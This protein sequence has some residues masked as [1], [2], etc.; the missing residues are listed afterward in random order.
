MPRC[1]HSRG[2]ERSGRSIEPK[3]RGS[4]WRRPESCSLNPDGESKVE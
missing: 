2:G 1:S 3:S 4:V